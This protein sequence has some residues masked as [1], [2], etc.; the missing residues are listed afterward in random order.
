MSI[1]RIFLFLTVL[2]ALSGCNVMKDLGGAYNMTQC[3]YD[4]NS[5]SKLSL[6]GT[7]LSKGVTLA[8]A[9]KL[10]ALLSG[11]TPSSLPLDM[12][13]NLNVNNPNQTAAALQ[14]LQYILSID[15]VQFTTGSLNQALSIPAGGTQVLPL[16]I[17]VDLATLISGGSKE[18]V[19]GIAKNFIGIGDKQSSV[20]LQL[21]PTF[22]VGGVPITSPVYIP[23]NFSFGGMK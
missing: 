22:S 10:L 21:K 16:N 19:I 6:A 7:D 18:A 17:G 9:P 8:S 11:V 20:T 5:I 13:L 2:I 4:Y 23:V 12:T 1:K 15:D 3:K 14:G